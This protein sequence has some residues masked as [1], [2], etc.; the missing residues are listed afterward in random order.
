M[1]SFQFSL[2]N[3]MRRLREFC[4]GCSG[5]CAAKTLIMCL[6][7]QSLVPEVYSNHV[8]RQCSHNCSRHYS[9]FDLLGHRTCLMSCCTQKEYERR[10]YLLQ[11]PP[12]F[13][14]L[15]D[16]DTC[17][18]SVHNHIGEQKR[19]LKYQERQ[20]RRW[21]NT[22][23]PCISTHCGGLGGENRVICIL[24]KCNRF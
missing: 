20:K 23:G 16:Y 3:V 18:S 8:M 11:L 22:I 12:S 15:R 13:R 19:R 1:P 2:N 24:H 6:L 14:P 21:G 10:R 9:P 5:N 7:L 4:S 17:R